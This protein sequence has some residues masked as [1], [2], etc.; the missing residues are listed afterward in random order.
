MELTQARKDRERKKV[1]VKGDK[2]EAMVEGCGKICWE[3]AFLTAKI[4]VL[5]E[6]MNS[7]QKTFDFLL[8]SQ[9]LDSVYELIQKFEQADQESRDLEE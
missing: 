6:K 9:G 5:A 1:T 7:Y 3:L 2:G 4:H 8:K